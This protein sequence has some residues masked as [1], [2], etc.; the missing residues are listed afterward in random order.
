MKLNVSSLLISTTKFSVGYCVQ[1][2]GDLPPLP[3]RFAGK[4]QLIYWAP[5][6][7]TVAWENILHIFEFETAEYFHTAACIRSQAISLLLEL[8]LTAMTSFGLSFCK[9]FNTSLS[10]FHC[11]SFPVLFRGASLNPS[12]QFI[13]DCHTHKMYYSHWDMPPGTATWMDI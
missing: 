10:F 1:L 4:S 7:Y 12:S 8:S 9:H 2:R 11:F 13:G 6:I 5:L 3:C